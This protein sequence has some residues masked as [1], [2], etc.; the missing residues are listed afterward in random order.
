MFHRNI[1]LIIAGLIVATG[2]WQFTESNIQWNFSL[3]LSAIP[4]F[5]TLKMNSS[6]TCLS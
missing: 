5:Y 3:L 2:I 6:F 1:K 4:F